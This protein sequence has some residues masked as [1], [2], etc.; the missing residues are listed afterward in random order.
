MSAEHEPQP[1]SGDTEAA[2]PSF[3]VVAAGPMSSG[4]ILRGALNDV[5]MSARQLAFAMSL[6][7]TTVQAWVDGRRDLT[8]SAIERMPMSVR[9]RVIARMQERAEQ[10]RY[11]R[12]VLPPNKHVSITSM[13]LGEYA[14]VVIDAE[15][16]NVIEDHE[17]AK[18]AKAARTIETV[19]R[20][21]AQDAEARS[22]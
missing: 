11:R 10:H 18:I 15:A 5:R 19:A 22:P 21:A 9:E 12:S 7:K 20:N 6:S 4:A 16:D 1:E 2:P 17:F 8:I 13:S 3:V 14:R